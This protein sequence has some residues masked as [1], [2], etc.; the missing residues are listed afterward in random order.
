MLNTIEQTE[1]LS[2]LFENLKLTPKINPVGLVTDKRMFQHKCDCTHYEQPTRLRAV[3]QALKELP[4]V[5]LASHIATD[6]ELANCHDVATI[7]S[8]IRQL[9]N[10][11]FSQGD[12][13]AVP[14]KTENAAR[15]AAG[16]SIQLVRDILSGSI[17]S[18]FAAVRPPGHHSHYDQ[19]SSFCFFNN[20]LLAAVEASKSEKVLL[21]DFDVH[22]GDGTA[23][24]LKTHLKQNKN[25]AYVSLHRYDDAEY[26]PTTGHSGTYLD[27]RLLSIAHNGGQDDDYYENAFEL[28]VI[29][30][31]KK[32]E[33]TFIVV[34]AGFDAAKNDPLGESFVTPDG[35]RNMIRQL[36]L[37]SRKIALILEGGYDLSAISASACAC[38]EVLLYN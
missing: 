37:I 8:Q 19:I 17:E 23:N 24:I 29:P 31:A 9:S 20:A 38:V 11:I 4:L 7:L 30:F 35:Y 22:Y 3:L 25:I 10:N 15:L 6:A 27:G 36:Q 18:G 5:R 21:V 13:Y 2:N 33:T 1:S 34:S 16:C 26:Y 32:F 12:M 14:E 28:E